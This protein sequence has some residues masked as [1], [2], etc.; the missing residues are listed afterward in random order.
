LLSDVVIDTGDAGERAQLS[1]YG[2]KI[3]VGDTRIADPGAA[4]SFADW[5]VDL[6]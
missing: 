3:H 4:W 2:P 5:L 1:E 6:L